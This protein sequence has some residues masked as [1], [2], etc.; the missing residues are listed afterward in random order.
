M[1]WG[2][3]LTV[4][5]RFQVKSGSHVGTF[6]SGNESNTAADSLI[7]KKTESSAAVSPQLATTASGC[8]A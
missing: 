8:E 6:K 4:Y 7:V 1:P 3:V 2:T 5:M